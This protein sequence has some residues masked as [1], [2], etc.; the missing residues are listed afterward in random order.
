[1]A[2]IYADSDCSSHDEVV[3]ADGRML[4][5][6]CGPI[7]AANGELLG[8]V[9]FFRDITARKQTEAE[10]DDLLARL[11]IQIERLPLAYMHSGPDFRYTQWNPAAERI[12]GFTQA[13]VLGKHPFE[14]IVPRHSQ[15]LVAGV[16]DRQRVQRAFDRRLAAE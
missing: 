14:V 8:R 13:E 15:A 1:M 7:R 4:D 6:Y 3:L 5:R 12:F 2:A 9:W 16:F 10:R 11:R